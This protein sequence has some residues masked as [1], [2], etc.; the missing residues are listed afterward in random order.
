MFF[1]FPW[2]LTKLGFWG[3][4]ASL[5]ITVVSFLLLATVLKRFAID[6]I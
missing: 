2:L 4:L 1:A 3:R 6:L 5:G